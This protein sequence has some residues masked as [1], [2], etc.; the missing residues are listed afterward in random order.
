MAKIDR[1]REI[2][3]GNKKQKKTVKVGEKFEDMT[4]TQANRFEELA[5]HGIPDL[6]PDANSPGK[7][8]Y[9]L[10]EVSEHLN[11]SGRQLMQQAASGSFHLFVNAAGLA[12]CWR[13]GAPE[14]GSMSTPVQTLVSGYLALT[15]RSCNGMIGLGSCNVSVLEFRCP[16]DPAAI[17]LDHETMEALIAWGED[18]KY[19][20]LQEPL[21][22]EEDKV[23]LIAP[24]P[25]LADLS[26]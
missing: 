8:H 18:D 10:A 23:V 9:T 13:R 24:L 19:F 5:Q 12:G 1:W 16:S 15:S 11:V 4:G 6:Q 26:S 17:E 2:F 21:W 3:R 14:G 7:V 22:V 20:C 25:N